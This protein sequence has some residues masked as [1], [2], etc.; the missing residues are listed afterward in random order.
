MALMDGVLFVLG[1]ILFVI[2]GII[3]V[4]GIPNMK[5][6]A[7]IIATP[8]SPIAQAPGNA[9]VE[10]KGRILPSEQGLVATP[11]SGRHAVWTRITVQEWRSRGRSSYWATLVNE[12]E[13]RM[14]FVD[15]GS[16]Q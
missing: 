4:V 14:F 10:V 1:G 8:T 7:R 11:F 9:A 5:R 3:A 16:G 12:V 6:R 2:G 15:D 13:M